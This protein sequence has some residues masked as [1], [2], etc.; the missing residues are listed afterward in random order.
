MKKPRDA[1]RTSG[2]AALRALPYWYRVK[3]QDTLYKLVRFA[4]RM[5]Q[6]VPPL[7]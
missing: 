5:V 3:G 6:V 2:V 1:R 4:Q 7:P